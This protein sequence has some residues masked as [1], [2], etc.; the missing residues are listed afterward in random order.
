MGPGE[1]T[2][3]NV[4]MV[5]GC[6]DGEYVALYRRLLPPVFEVFRPELVLVSAGVD[7]HVDDPMG[8]MK[9]T[10]SGFAGLTKLLLDLAKA[11]CGGRIVFCLEGGY[12]ASALADS[13]L[14]MV[15]ALNG[16]GIIDIEALAARAD[17]GKL[18]PMLER[19]LYTH[20]LYYR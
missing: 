15:D 17:P 5:K 11:H 2:T 20:R 18:N 13:V 16:R 19:C 6:G 14:A 7:I 1:G 3:M 4:P 8:G 12:N 10:P 9:V